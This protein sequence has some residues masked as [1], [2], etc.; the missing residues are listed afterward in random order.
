M[1][2][3]RTKPYVPDDRV[4][5]VARLEELRF[6]MMGDSFEAKK[7]YGKRL[8]GAEADRA[9][10]WIAEIERALSNWPELGPPRPNF[11]DTIEALNARRSAEVE[12]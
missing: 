7:I 4:L 1:K 6:A 12:S 5:D 3:R 11:E 9:R 2:T 10:A 8:V